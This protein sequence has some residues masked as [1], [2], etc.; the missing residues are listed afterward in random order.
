[1][2]KN[3]LVINNIKLRKIFFIVKFLKLNIEKDFLLKKNLFLYLK[4]DLHSSLFN[5][6]L[7][8][9]L[10][11]NKKISFY[12]FYIF[13]L[14]NKKFIA[15]L[16]KIIFFIKKN[17][18]ILKKSS[19]ITSKEFYSRFL[20]YFLKKGNKS[21]AFFFINK[22]FFLLKK[23]FK[24][25]F[26]MLFPILI[27]K[28]K[29]SVEVKQIKIRRIPTLIPFPINLKRNCFLIK[30]WISIGLMHSKKNKIKTYKNLFLE[31]NNI[32]KK[33]NSS[34]IKEKNQNLFLAIKNKSNI[35]FRW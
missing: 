8:L 16:F 4:K 12:K 9:L 2:K 14:F 15:N 22:T 32:L 28:L 34:S 7:Y 18:L 27:R 33:K 19:F 29:T 21:K 6:F 3:N 31:F 26:I 25:S 1:M 30:K 20:G 23:Y 24:I 5:K 11:K 13:L 35:H 10:N 17:N